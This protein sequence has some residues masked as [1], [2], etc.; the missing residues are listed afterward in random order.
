[1]KTAFAKL[2]TD[3]TLFQGRHTTS[4]HNLKQARCNKLARL[5]W[6]KD[7]AC[8]QSLDRGV[9]LRIKQSLEQIEHSI[10]QMVVAGKRCAEARRVCMQAG[11]PISSEGCSPIKLALIRLCDSWAITICG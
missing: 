5:F 11:L 1:M 6:D 8:E 9:C 4:G 2:Q 3:P 7:A 10:R